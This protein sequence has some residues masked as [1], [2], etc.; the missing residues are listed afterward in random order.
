M[1]RLQSIHSFELLMAVV[2]CS[3]NS[4]IIADGNR[5]D[6]PDWQHLQLQNGNTGTAA[7]RLALSCVRKF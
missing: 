4:G 3:M 1:L 7:K 2:F 6:L 5:W